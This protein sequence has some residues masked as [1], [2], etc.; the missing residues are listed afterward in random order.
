ML[1]LRFK[2]WV[3]SVLGMDT[4]FYLRNYNFPPDYNLILNK[5]QEKGQKPIQPPID[6]LL[7]NETP[8][9]E[10]V[11]AKYGIGRIPTTPEYAKYLWSYLDD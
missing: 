8:L 2:L 1:W 11:A 4:N 7:E 3:R 5:C 6:L 10:N 9:P